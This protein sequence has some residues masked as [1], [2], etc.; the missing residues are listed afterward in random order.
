MVLEVIVR[1]RRAS[2]GGD[3]LVLTIPSVLVRD[4]SFPFKPDQYVK[5]RIDRENMRLVVEHPHRYKR[6]EKE[7]EYVKVPVE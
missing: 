3:T 7:G 2:S 4:S 1:L 5:I 6:E